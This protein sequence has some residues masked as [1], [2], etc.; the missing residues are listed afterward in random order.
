MVYLQLMLQSNVFKMVFVYCQDWKNVQALVGKTGKEGLKR[1]CLEC[2]AAKISTA[3]ASRAKELLDKQELDEVRDVSAG[4][5]TF[6]VFVSHS[7]LIDLNQII[8]I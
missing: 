7:F 6:Y 5:A 8:S 3:A 4:A 2:N 1:R